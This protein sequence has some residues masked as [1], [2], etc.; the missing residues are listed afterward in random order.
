[1]DAAENAGA[2]SV[3]RKQRVSASWTDD[4]V[5][6]VVVKYDRDDLK[7][8]ET[9]IVCIDHRVSQRLV[10]AAKAN[11]HLAH[12]KCSILSVRSSKRSCV[13]CTADPVTT[14]RTTPQ[15]QTISTEPS[16][17]PTQF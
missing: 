11:R 2:S 1:M 5:F 6:T 3:G 12:N 16:G 10:H 9:I 14:P 15:P 8:S 13:C 4:D 17:V 7:I